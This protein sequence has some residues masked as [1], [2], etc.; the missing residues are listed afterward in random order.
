[1]SILNRRGLL[2]DFKNSKISSG[3]INVTTDPETANQ[4][5]FVGFRAGV[6]KELM[7][8]DAGERIVQEAT[9]LRDETARLKN[10]TQTI[11]DSAL[12][13]ITTAKTDALTDIGTAKKD[14]VD[15]ITTLETNVVK[16]VT[17]LR[18]ETKGYRD[19]SSDYSTTSKSWAVGDT[20]SR[21]GEDTDNSKFYSQVAQNI[22]DDSQKVLADAKAIL[23]AAQKKITGANFTVDMNTGMLLYNDDS[24]YI[25]HIDE[26]TGE[27]M[28]DYAS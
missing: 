10:D 15:T 1:M 13:E 23:E 6:A 12:T 14:A 3:E 4:R 28:W 2:K 25:F 5:V 16:E 21:E 19:D 24:D 20:G 11:K 9:D 17:D 7:T 18:D 22:N 27:L 8:T 26:T